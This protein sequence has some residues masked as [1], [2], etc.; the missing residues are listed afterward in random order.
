MLFGLKPKG[1]GYGLVAL[2]A[3]WLMFVPGE[4][5]A[6]QKHKYF[7]KAPPGTTKFTQT[8]LMD[9]GDVPGHQ[10]RIAELQSKYPG[11]APVY[12]GLKVVEA[13]T[14]L[15]SDYVD[16]NGNSF[17]YGV[18]TLENGDKIFARTEIL[19]HTTVGADGARRTSF[20][21]VATLT[22]GTGKFKAIRG[23]LRGSG[24]SDMK[25]ATSGTQTEGEYWFEK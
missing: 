21:S 5:A 14:V 8:H 25:T 20:T 18:S 13:R 16:G 6:Q 1:I 24:F 22:G 12:D 2:V 9:V 7:F 23:T 17:T 3:V 19:A 4:A 10:V 15:V 11:D